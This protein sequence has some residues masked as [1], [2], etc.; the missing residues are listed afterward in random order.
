MKYPPGS[1]IVDSINEKHFGLVSFMNF[2]T[3]FGVITSGYSDYSQCDSINCLWAID[4]IQVTDKSVFPASCSNSGLNNL[5]N[6]MF[7]SI[8]YSC[9]SSTFLL[10]HKY[11]NSIVETDFANSFVLGKDYG[12]PAF[13]G[14]TRGIDINNAL[15][16]ETNFARQLPDGVNNIGDAFSRAKSYPYNAIYTCITNN[17]SGDPEFGL[18][19]YA[20]NPDYT[21]PALQITRYDNSIQITSS[22]FEEISYTNN[23]GVVSE[24]SLNSSGL[25]VINNISPNGIIFAFR[26]ASHGCFHKTFPY[27]T[28]L[29]LQNTTI[30][31]SQYVIASDVTAGN[32]IESSRT[33][34]DVTVS[35]GVE[36]E[37]EASG[38]VTLENGFKVEK[39]AFFAVYPACY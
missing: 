26:D 19:Y 39:G 15:N 3:P 38:K 7:P 25:T 5:N 4:T 12:G 17:L 10:D 30:G 21:I 16:L 13:I 23:D 9:G 22:G 24:H 14:Y 34:G 36:Y 37:I 29:I 1:I 18:G 31:I 11:N 8:G 27:I 32:S 6:K 33:C 35:D 28:P 20:I 2:A